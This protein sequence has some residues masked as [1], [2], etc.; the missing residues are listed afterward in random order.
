HT[1][2]TAFRRVSLG[3]FRQLERHYL[4]RRFRRRDGCSKLA[5]ATKC[6]IRGNRARTPYRR[7]AD[8]IDMNTPRSDTELAPH[9]TEVSAPEPLR[10]RRPGPETELDEGDRLGAWRLVKRLAKG[11]MGA[12]YLAERADGH[13]EQRAAIK[14]IRGVPNP[15]TLVH[16]TR[17]RQILAT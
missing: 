2:R 5:V 6:N 16:F 13:F 17:E 9:P 7:G 1:I 12:V 4:C 11:G 3:T 8:R 14:L 15:E 10:Q